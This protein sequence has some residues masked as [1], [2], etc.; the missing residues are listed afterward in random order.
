MICNMKDNKNK[1]IFGGVGLLVVL[2][3][4]IYLAV[5]VIPNTLILLTKASGSSNVSAKNSIIIGEKVL[6]SADGKDSCIVFVFALDNKGKGVAS[7]QIQLSGL[8][9]KTA[10]TD[11]SGKAKFELT[12]DQAK[13]YELKASSGGLLLGKTLKVTFR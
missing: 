2:G 9:D 1:I 10:I 11:A 7:R 6:A 5:A 13:Q 3:L 4:V 12:S 8:G